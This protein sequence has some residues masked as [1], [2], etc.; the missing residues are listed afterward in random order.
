MKFIMGKCFGL[1]LAAEGGEQDGHQNNR[2]LEVFT[3]LGMKYVNVDPSYKQGIERARELGLIPSGIANVV[4]SP[5]LHEMVSLFDISHKGRAF[6]MMRHP[7]ERA[8]SMYYNLQKTDPAMA[9]VP[10]IDWARGKGGIENNWMVRYLVNQI[11]GDFALDLAKIVLKR[12][13]LIG[14]LEEKEE[15][16]KRF[17][18]FFGWEK[19]DDSRA[20]T[21]AQSFCVSRIL[22]NGIN[23]NSDRYHIPKKGTQEY[24]LIAH[25]NQFDIKL[26]NYAKELFD[27]QTSQFGSESWKR[28]GKKLK[29][30]KSESSLRERIP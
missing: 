9:N 16:I 30:L 19:S 25:Q 17:Q 18:S 20:K 15:S 21:E 29:L 3:N 22:D 5:Y 1:T 14:F 28:Q 27:E 7:V 12:K 6:T 10:L 26:Y 24:S 11:E 23:T 4:V 2:I 8:V 13:F